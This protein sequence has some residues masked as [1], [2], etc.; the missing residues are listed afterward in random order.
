MNFY[1]EIQL[2]FTYRNVI[3]INL[4]FYPPTILKVYFKNAR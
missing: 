2:L 4:Y 3:T 1:N